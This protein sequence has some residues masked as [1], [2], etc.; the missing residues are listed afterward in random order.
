[1]GT[2]FRD[3]LVEGSEPA[4]QTQKPLSLLDRIIR[5]SSNPGDL[6]FDPFCG[7]ATTLVAAHALGDREWVGID[8]SPKAAELVV[9]RITELQGASISDAQQQGALFREYVHRVDVPLR[10]DLGILPAY[11]CTA[12]KQ[13]LYG[14]QEGDCAACREHFAARH[15][16]VDH[17]I[18][19]S[20]GGTDHL[21]NLQLL[22]SH[23]NRRKGDR[24]MAYLRSK[25]QLAA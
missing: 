22:C 7:C 11:N 25:L 12:N 6:V 18:A 3:A 8:I 17:I 9:E 2:S 24:G 23:C 13:T 14:S 1:M 10:T 16:E 4:T 20:K 19:R 5:A 15:L 21:S